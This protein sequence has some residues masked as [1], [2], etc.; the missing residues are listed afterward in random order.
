M[1][2]NSKIGN[3][4]TM[5]ELDK[6]KRFFYGESINSILDN[7]NTGKIQNN[8]EEIYKYDSFQ[9][10]NQHTF[11]QWIFPTMRKSHY[12]NDAPLLSIED[13]KILREDG[14]IIQWLIKMKDKM[15]N[16][17][18]IDPKE[19][20][21]ANILNGHNGLRLSR[22]IECLTLFGIDISYIFLKLRELT[23]E[24]VLKPHSQYY[25]GERIF[26]WLIRYKQSLKCFSY[27]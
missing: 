13:I 20:K 11:I 1:I 18:G 17:W 10:E 16:Y 8:I 7:E 6:I 22:A 25:E 26:I 2:F 9:L 19:P 3:K 5:T 4:I 27:L 14:I 15:F 24:G 12:N 23:I 21:R